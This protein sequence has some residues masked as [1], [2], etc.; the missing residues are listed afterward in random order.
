[1]DT[2]RGPE[3]TTLA[4]DDVIQGARLLRAVLDGTTYDGPVTAGLV[5]GLAVFTVGMMMATAALGGAEDMEAQA[6]EVRRMLDRSV[7][8]ATLQALARDAE[9]GD[10]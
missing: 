8:H 9:A 2:P 5:Q 6:A 1:V 10:Q 3:L 4:A 7:A